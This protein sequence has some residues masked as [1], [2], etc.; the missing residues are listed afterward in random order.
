MAS[1]TVVVALFR[2]GR[3]LEVSRPRTWAEASAYREG[4]RAG[5][6]LSGADDLH[7]YLLPG[8][9]E[10]MAFVEPAAEVARALSWLPRVL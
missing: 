8:E 2:Q 4:L 7:A 10:P 9:E 1:G 5:A 6:G 3:F